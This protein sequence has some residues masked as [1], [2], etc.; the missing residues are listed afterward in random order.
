MTMTSIGDL[1]G[2]FT[3]RLHTM[4]VKTDLLRLNSEL[5]SGRPADLVAHLG[6]DTARVALMDRDIEVARARSTAATG[7]GQ[8]MATMQTALDSIE[9]VR[10]GLT[11]Q[12]L[13]LTPSS[14]A[15]E[16]D[17]AG[18]A[19]AE[20]FRDIVGRLNASH[21]GAAL[22]AGVATD[23]PALADAD[24]ML[25]SL[26]AAAAGAVTSDDVIAAVNTW[27][28]DPAG[29]FA[30]MGYLGDTGDPLARRIEEGVTVTITP[31]AD[32][33]ALKDL[34]R[35]TAILALSVDPGLGLA[36]STTAALVTGSLP[37]LFSAGAPLTDLRAEAGL[38]E[39]RTAEAATRNGAMATQL[40]IMRNELA[41]VDPYA[42]AVALKETETQLQ[43]Q[44]ILTSRLS[45]LSLV[46][47]LK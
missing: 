28:D 16:L 35:V 10:L 19:G 1:A 37:D 25:A 9:T 13:P 45:G 32:H 8:F 4:R 31:R 22:F 36:R 29:G 33:A 20:A 15:L 12:L 26:S 46:N 14:S 21:G 7:L 40:T 42:T 47:F 44:F 23:G 43:T 30:T 17:R 27:F 24:A 34:M 6:G 5:S 11:R 18:A 39:E 2:N 41:L 38:A 3:N